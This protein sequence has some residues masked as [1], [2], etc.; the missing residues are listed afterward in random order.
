MDWHWFA[1][2]FRLPV[3]VIGIGIGYWLVTREWGGK[4]EEPPE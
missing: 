1:D 3:I 4:K 2:T